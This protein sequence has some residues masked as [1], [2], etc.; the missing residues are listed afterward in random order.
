MSSGLP[1][2]ADIALCGR[3]VSKVPIP[4][5]RTAANSV[6]Y[7]MTSSA[8]TCNVWGTVTSRAL[9]VT[10]SNLV[11]CMTGRSE[12]FSPFGIRPAVSSR[13][14]V[15]IGEAYAIADQTAG[16]GELV[17]FVDR[18]DLYRAAR[19]TIWSRLLRKIG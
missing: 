14:A 12:G 6:L 9:V 16:I 19:A 18:R 15:G 1:L 5:S 17:P 8:A 4:D 10:S 3:H 2:K 11:G 7:S 13:L